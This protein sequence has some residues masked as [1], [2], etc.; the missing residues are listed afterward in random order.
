MQIRHYQSLLFFIL[1]TIAHCTFSQ[2]R[3]KIGLALSGGGVRGLAHIGILKAIDEAGIK[4]D[5]IAG[6]SIGAIVGG[7]YA[8]GYSAD[9]IEKIALSEDWNQLIGNQL[10]L[11]S[12]SIE[13]KPEYNKYI[14]EFEVKRGRFQLP[15]GMIEGQELTLE[16]SR[17]FMPVYKERNFRRFNIPFVCMATDLTTGKPVLLDTGSIVNSI[18]AS[19]AISSIFTPVEM[20]NMLL[21]DG[22]IAF[23]FP[24]DI[25]RS[26]GA[27][28]VIGV[29]IG[30]PLRKK[31]EIKSIID[32]FMQINSFADLRNFEVQKKNAN[33]L[34]T[35][36]LNGVYGTD[37]TKS[38]TIIKRGIQTGKL[39]VAS[40][41]RLNDSLNS[42]YSPQIVNHNLPKVDTIAIGKIEII[43]NK[44]VSNKLIMYHLR[45]IENR[46]VT[47]GRINE[48][49]KNLYG[50]RYFSHIRYELV[51]MDSNAV[52]KLNLDEI[53]GTYAKFAVNYHSFLGA[54]LILNATFKNKLG[55][56][57]KILLSA[58]ISES[59]MW[60]S[61][62]HKYIG[63]RHKYFF[64]S[65]FHFSR[66][67]FPIYQ[68]SGA[69]TNIYKQN[70]FALDFRITRIFGVNAMLG[71]GIK[72]EHH[73]VNPEVGLNFLFKRANY[74]NLN[75]YAIYNFNTLNN[76]MFPTKGHELVA[77]ANYISEPSFRSTEAVDSLYSILGLEDDFSFSQPYFQLKVNGKVFY[78]VSKK[79]T[80]ITAAQIGLTG[81]ITHRTIFNDF[82]I[83]GIKA[84][85]RNNIAFA[86]FF[87]YEFF[88]PN[89]IVFSESV[90][91]EMSKNIFLTG[92]FNVGSFQIKLEDYLNKLQTKDYAIFGGSLSLGFNTFLGPVHLTAMKGSRFAQDVRFYVNIGFNF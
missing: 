56:N 24:V 6:T 43:G 57:S 44:T 71:V 52:L 92:A 69:L 65:G 66:L 73:I 59:P 53:P 38:D 86:G 79:V 35:P 81:G 64:Q 89:A 90:Q 76:K 39:Y 63:Q 30:E 31:A 47:T 42:I 19:M 58:N 70:Y 5:Y 82:G 54:S 28:I 37:F 20:N 41:K 77:E 22:G 45:N 10:S 85:Y 25:V 16:L 60:R 7:L 55:D 1:L 36:D 51:A 14:S 40:L 67:N 3:P 17:L 46:K 72:G 75:Y 80:L 87:D 4:I 49:L 91:W 13:E 21:A 8:A 83:G 88:Q 34:I 18:R 29:D 23:N 26:M 62:F 12:I 48:A 84:V 74:T 2:K 9:S 78:P 33:I 50:T 68:P 15:S 61:E 27:D 32:V 11:K